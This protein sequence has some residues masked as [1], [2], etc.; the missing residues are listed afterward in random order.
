[1]ARHQGIYLEL[2]ADANVGNEEI[3]S[4]SGGNDLSDRSGVVQIVDHE[5]QTSS[6]HVTVRF[7]FSVVRQIGQFDFGKAAEKL[8]RLRMSLNQPVYSHG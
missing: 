8:L 6:H 2:L 5:I 3:G 7:E 1:M 4:L